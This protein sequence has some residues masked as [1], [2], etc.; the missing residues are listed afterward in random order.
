MRNLLFS[1]I[2]ILITG[3][4][5]AITLEDW[6][7]P[8]LGSSAIILLNNIN[9]PAGTNPVYSHME[10]DP[11]ILGGTRS[12]Q[13]QRTSNRGVVSTAI[14]AQSP[15]TPSP[16]LQTNVG[17]NSSALITVTWDADTL[18]GLTN[19]SGL[20][21]IDFTADGSD[22]LMFHIDYDY[23]RFDGE[24]R[25]TFYDATNPA[26]F[27]SYTHFIVSDLSTSAVDIPFSLFNG[28]GTS[29]VFTNVG[30]ITLELDSVDIASEIGIY[31]IHTNGVC[32][33]VPQTTEVVDSCGVCD[34]RDA[35]KDTCGVCFGD[36]S[37]CLNRC[38]PINT[39]IPELDIGSNALLHNASRMRTQALNAGVSRNRA[40][41]I[42]EEA[43]RSSNTA[44]IEVNVN[45]PSVV[46]SCT[47]PGPSCSSIDI[48]SAINIYANSQ[49]SMLDNI[50][51][52]RTRALRKLKKRLRKNTITRSQYNKR[53]RRIRNINNNAQSQLSTN[54]TIAASLP[55][56]NV[57]C[58][59]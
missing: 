14:V 1:I 38:F 49:I 18:P 47:N 39:P 29:A 41:S 45:Y 53:R 20:N 10:I 12:V 52:L 54:N 34:G 26:L 7:K 3:N 9:D 23:S 37:S 15:S 58:D 22:R 56:T 25:W 24:V 55:T 17:I 33:D 46:T 30:A 5:N 8:N 35:A 11:E 44:W 50:R 36:G 51:N 27:V 40:N 2:I 59:V 19:P 31:A 6:S 43:Q 42:F 32:T 21:G 48:S 13:T 16:S 4:A 28:T 57:Q